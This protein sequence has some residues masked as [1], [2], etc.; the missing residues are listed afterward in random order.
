MET[1]Y[2][3][4]YKSEKAKA[5]LSRYYN[6]IMSNWPV[7]YNESVLETPHGRTHI[8]C[9]GKEDG[10]PLLLFHG[11]GNNSLTWRYNVEQLGRHFRL[12][13]ID[14][15]NDPGKSQ[16]SKGFNAATGY[17][18]WIGELL[19]SL[20]LGKVSILGHSKG[21]WI[22]LNTVIA[23]PDRIDKV[24][25]LAPAAGINAKLDPKFIRKSILVGM[26]PSVKNITS[27]LQYI[28][29]PNRPVNEQYAQYLSELIRGTR[30]KLIRHRQFTDSELMGIEN[31]VL[32]AFGENEV[33]I[34]WQ[35]VIERAKKLIKNLKVQVVAKTGHALHGE[36]PEEVN[37][38]IIDF[39]R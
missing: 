38:I 14:T 11:T 4:V 5:R 7:P 22:A 39:L 21:G 12:Y 29:S 17:T 25:L 26:F 32:L 13:L 33:S 19:D 8:L 37:S 30:S 18:A 23:I 6:A 2:L 3:S 28:S 1:K 35:S 36:K 24:I 27:Y 20:N 10:K 16:A 9:C 15:V 31:P 34:D